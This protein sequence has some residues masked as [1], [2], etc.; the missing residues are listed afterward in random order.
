MRPHPPLHHLHLQEISSPHK[1]INSTDIKSRLEM[2]PSPLQQRR[3]HNTL[4]FQKLL[5]LRDG[6][7]PFTL[8][9]DTLE[10]SG[11]PVIRE[12]ARRAKV[13]YLPYCLLLLDFM[14]EI[15]KCI[16]KCMLVSIMQVLRLQ[17]FRRFRMSHV[18]H[19]FTVLGSH[20]SIMMR[21]AAT[22]KAHFTL[23]LPLLTP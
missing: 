9:L 13:C 12:S 23:D 4:L 15:V 14:A 1:S 22:S 19:I 7:S 11:G 2:A 16:A 5:N 8:V 21:D 18:N 17:C 6:A 10:Q 20:P 3:T